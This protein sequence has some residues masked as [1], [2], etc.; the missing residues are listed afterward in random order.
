MEISPN[1]LF[2]PKGSDQNAHIHGRAEVKLKNPLCCRAH[3]QIQT[4]MPLEPYDQ[5]PFGLYQ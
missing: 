1:G 4:H 2:W 3:T 5:K